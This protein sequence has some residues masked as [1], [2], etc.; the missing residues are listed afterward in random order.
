[1]AVWCL[2]AGTSTSVH[3]ACC[4]AAS[5]TPDCCSCCPACGLLSCA[6]ACCC[7]PHD[8]RHIFP[9]HSWVSSQQGERIFFE[10]TA[11]LPKDTPE[12]IKDEREAELEALRVSR[13]GQGGSVCV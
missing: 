11:Y 2:S 12:Q 3:T 1:M 8:G 4:S 6:A 13:S 7:S 5:S 10:G 9:I